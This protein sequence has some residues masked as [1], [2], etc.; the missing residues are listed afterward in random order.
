MQEPPTD[1]HRIYP[2]VL[3]RGLYWLFGL[4]IA[5]ALVSIAW[6]LLRK[7]MGVP[8]GFW[9]R[10]G[11]LGP[12]LAPLL[13]IW[14]Y[15]LWRTRSIRRALQDSQGRLCTHCAYD[16]SCLKP[17]GTCPE[18]GRAYDIDQDKVLWEAVGARYGE[19]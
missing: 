17:S 10:Y 14:P 12:S 19:A 4:T 13:I 1:H 9:Y 3:R 11:A 7:P 6:V 18:C 16:V 15:W 5:C 2:P 8:R